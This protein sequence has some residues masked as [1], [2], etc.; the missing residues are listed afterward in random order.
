M[1]KLGLLSGILAPASIAFAL[2]AV[3]WLVKPEWVHQHVVYVI[4]YCALLTLLTFWITGG[5]AGTKDFP[6]AV[7]GATSLRLMLSATALLVYLYNVEEDRT[8]FI[9]TFFISY[10]LFVGF[11]IRYL[12]ATLRRKTQS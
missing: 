10:F 8:L 4:V 5:K 6:N 1:N 3:L 11:E 9:L 7:L 12:L 2:V